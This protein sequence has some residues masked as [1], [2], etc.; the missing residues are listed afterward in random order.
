MYT[1]RVHRQNKVNSNLD[2]IKMLPIFL[3]ILL[4]FFNKNCYAAEQSLAL[5]TD[6]ELMQHITTDPVIVLFTKDDCE[7]CKKWEEELVGLRDELVD[8]LSAWVVKVSG[9]YLR[10]LY[11]PY[12]EPALVFF[13]NSVPLLYD[14]PLDDKEIYDTFVHNKEPIVKELTDETFEHLTQASS[15][16]TTGDWFVMF[17][18][19][20]CVECQR[21]G[22]RWEAV[23][24]KIKRRINT[25]RVNKHTTGA[26]T[27][28]RFSVFEVP[29][30]ILFRQGKMYRY[31]VPK[32]DVNAMVSFAENWYKNAQGEKVPVPQSPFDD[33]TLMIADTLRENPWI[34]KLGSMIIC[35]MVIVS[36][37]SK[38]RNKNEVADKKKDK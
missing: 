23:G 38:L 28:R 21:L 17:Y 15:G 35:I 19:D 4:S 5:F 30:L 14:G 1:I 18:S 22:A 2:E 31:Q 27:A 7:E 25:A 37:A 10:K 33:L 20:S 3:I 29:Q 24:A 32:Y 12:K 9:S 11:T 13:R 16:A 36:V 26:A 34:M 8:S 6:E